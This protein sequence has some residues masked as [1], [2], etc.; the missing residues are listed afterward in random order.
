[1]PSSKEYS[2]P[3]SSGSKQTTLKTKLLLPLKAEI[4]LGNVKKAKT[5]RTNAWLH[6]AHETYQDSVISL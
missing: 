4:V 5:Q 2:L 1:M 3:V 6:P